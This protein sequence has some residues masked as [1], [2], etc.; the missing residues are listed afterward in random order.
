MTKSDKLLRKFDSI[1]E[2]LQSAQVR[3]QGLPIEFVQQ[4]IATHHHFHFLSNYDSILP[5]IA[6]QSTNNPEGLRG[7][8]AKFIF[9]RSQF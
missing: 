7:L 5:Q 3:L 9:K 2:L 1:N 6:N 8:V 4:F